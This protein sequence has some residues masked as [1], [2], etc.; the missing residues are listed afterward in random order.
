[1]NNIT[2]RI[3]SLRTARGLTQDALAQ[4]LHVTRQ[5]VSN[6]ENGKSQPDIDTI[7][8]LAQALNVPAEELIYGKKEPAAPSKPKG[9]LPQDNVGAQL[10]S[11]AKAVQFVGIFV[12]IAVG[13]LFGVLAFV[14]IPLGLFCTHVISMLVHGVGHA[15]E[16]SEQCAA[17]L[18][19]QP[20]EPEEI[21]TPPPSEPWTCVQCGTEN[22][23][24]VAYCQNCG[25]NKAWSEAQKKQNDSQE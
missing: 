22:W 6:W 19:Q 1:M 10:K 5:A 21:E 23:P 9:L 16:K 4:Q 15:A 24:R 7:I 3:R 12:S 25:T 11:L 17:F 8:K 18:L 13:L 2:N 14:I 20:E